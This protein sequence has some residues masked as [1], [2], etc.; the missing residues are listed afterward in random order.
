MTPLGL[1]RHELAQALGRYRLRV[2][3]LIHALDQGRA[4]YVHTATYGALEELTQALE[5]DL[6]VRRTDP[7]RDRMS[8]VESDVLVPLLVR[9]HHDLGR[10]QITPPSRHWLTTLR[11]ADE[12]VAEAERALAHA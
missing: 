11:A 6:E 12:Y 2:H 9:L 10:V 5:V 4:G 1:S 8:R 7:G 3:A